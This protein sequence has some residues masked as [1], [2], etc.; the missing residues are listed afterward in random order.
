MCPSLKSFSLNVQNGLVY[1]NDLVMYTKNFENITHF[2]LNVTV[3]PLSNSPMI[4]G[5]CLKDQL[6]V[7][8]PK[9]KQFYFHIQFNMYNQL[10]EQNDLISTFK[11]DYWV[12]EHQWKV[13]CHTRND[14]RDMYS[15]FI[16]S[17][18]YRFKIFPLVFPGII[19]STT[20][21]ESNVN[22]WS[23]IQCIKPLQSINIPL[24]QMLNDK[25]L[26]LTE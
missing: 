20:N 2:S 4:D 21:F 18:P 5:H 26:Q 3:D 7:Y 11:T 12:K 17:L 8:L 13:G 19:N 10:I 16:Y 24:M 1:F 9:L 22:S 6:L 23:S 25:F 15:Y 14:I